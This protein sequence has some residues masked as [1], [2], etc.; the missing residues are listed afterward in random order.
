MPYDE[1]QL[2]ISLVVGND[3][4]LD[5][6]KD[7]PLKNHLEDI[8]GHTVTLQNDD[9][10]NWNPENYDVIVISESVSSSKT[11]DLFDTSIPILTV[12]GSNADEAK[13]GDS[14]SSSGWK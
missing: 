2:N 5:S 1:S 9:W 4:N 3:D 12:E 6:Q 8:L 13:L 10:N 11:K 7:I 14:G